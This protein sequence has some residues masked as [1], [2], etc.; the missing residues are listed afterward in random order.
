MQWDE[1][2]FGL[3]YDLD[4]FMI[5]AVDDFNMG[6]MENKGLN[7]FNSKYVLAKPETATDDDYAG[8]EGVIAHEYFH[9]WTGN[10]VTCRDWFQL[11]LKEGLT[12][13]RDQQFSA[14]MTSRAVKRLT[15]VR[16][17]R[18]FQF[19]EDS[20]PM[21]HP[22]RPESYIEINN[23]YTVTVY[24]KGAE[25]IRMMHTL[26]G[27]EGFRRGMD[28][29]FERHDGQAVTCDDFVRAMEDGGGVDLSQFRNW[30]SQAGTPEL[31][32][33]CSY[34]AETA[35]CTL[36]MKQ[37]CPDTP[38]QSNKKP[39]HIPV[40][41]GLLDESG[42]QMDLHMDGENLGHSLVLDMKEAEQHHV[43]ENVP[44]KPL[45]SLL[46]GFSAPVKLVYDYSDQ[47]LRLLLSSDSDPFNRW[48]AGQ[49]LASRV[50]VGL[51]RDCQQ[52]KE[53]SLDP[54][55]IAV[56][57]DLCGQQEK[58][59][60]PAFLTQLFILP[61][62]KILG[63]QLE[64]IDPE[65]IHQARQFVRRSLAESLRHSLLQLYHDN[66]SSEPY[67]YDT[68][69][70]GRRSLKNMALSYLMLLDDEAVM[71]LCLRQFEQSGNMTDELAALQSLVHNPDCPERKSV[72]VSFY[73][74]WQ[75]D[76][77]VLDKWFSL[78]ATA[79]LPETL[80]E[81]KSLM[82]HPAFSIKNPNKVRSLV[83]A[84]CSANQ[85]CF[86]AADGEGYRFLADR[87][88]E[89]NSINPQIA[90][91]LLSPLSRWRRFDES[92][93]GLMRQELERILA[94]KKLSKDVFEVASKSLK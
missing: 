59:E 37:N 29:Y 24:E 67:H 93:Q 12:V 89:L 34:D 7:V 87:V 51:I 56:F 15:D 62:E 8:I 40:A 75:K 71:D 14:D 11:S 36:T 21:A 81:V 4:L 86:H 27:K 6:A 58:G 80:N 3:E 94:D 73:S 43:F 49:R 83:G 54:D 52:K 45:P 61:S 28:L 23:F 53:L 25:V 17:L 38:D 55:F 70:A 48:E 66:S 78:Q 13:F 10:R 88:L 91:R 5:V 22:V 74:Q 33:S 77:L 64:V 84:F 60:D 90:A 92:R 82:G 42:Q 30:Y 44:Q 47:E 41:M 20:G 35:T 57:Q 69:S 31:A 2:V 9:N 68:R 63:E 1:D 39:F 46:R 26:L 65:A 79:P 85:L 72:L 18:N 32:V 19:V 50:L 76:T 16:L